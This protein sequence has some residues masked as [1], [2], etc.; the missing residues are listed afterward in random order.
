M[1]ILR[2][3]DLAIVIVGDDVKTCIVSVSV[4]LL[5][6]LG[7][8]PLYRC[9]CQLYKQTIVVLFLNI[10]FVIKKYKYKYYREHI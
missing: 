5:A 2:R 9:H 6:R 1:F 8:R 3:L 4:F 7:K 10:F